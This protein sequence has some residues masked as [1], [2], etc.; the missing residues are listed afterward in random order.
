MRLTRRSSSRVI[1]QY[2][3][4]AAAITVLVFAACAPAWAYEPPPAPDGTLPSAPNQA[5]VADPAAQPAPVEAPAVDWHRQRRHSEET[6]WYG[7]QT[8]IAD[9]ASLVVVPI[10]A[11][12]TESEALAF[13]ALGGYLLAPPIIHAAHGRWGITFA[14]LG[15]RIGLPVVAALVGAA[16]DQDC[17]DFCAG[18]VVGL[19]AGIGG[20]VTLDA[21]LLS[22][23][24]VSDE[25]RD[26]A[27][28]RAARRGFAFT[29]LLA[30]R[31]EGGVDVGLAATF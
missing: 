3:L 13:V 30:P 16:V 22:D 31:K 6:Y 9:G 25:D 8:L 17:R 20:A 29:P 2:L 23:E 11:G 10:I 5:P 27:A 1:R 15:L 19:I 4:I 7:W 21:A 28:A 14:S 18:P 26:A 12:S 24:K